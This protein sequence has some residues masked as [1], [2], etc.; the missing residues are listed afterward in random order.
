M[1]RIEDSVRREG[2]DD[3]RG[4]SL[5]TPFFRGRESGHPLSVD[6]ALSLLASSQRRH[7]LVY[8]IECAPRDVTLDSAVDELSRNA[9]QY[10]GTK[11]TSS[12]R[13]SLVHNHLPKL[14]RAGVLTYHRH[15]G[16]LTYH[17]DPTLEMMV[18]YITELED[19]P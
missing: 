10:G 8:L 13:V 4:Q 19:D 12:V 6:Q 18:K 16:M 7:L 15:S 5:N 1:G 11:T 17:R 3:T 9:T 2:Q 14:E